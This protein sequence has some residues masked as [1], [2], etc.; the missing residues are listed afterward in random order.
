M[1]HSS[2]EFSGFSDMVLVIHKGGGI[3]LWVWRLVAMELSIVT[4]TQVLRFDITI[5]F[6]E[7]QLIITTDAWVGVD[8]KESHRNLGMGI[9]MFTCRF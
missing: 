5:T 3:G 8:Q 4:F 2:G 6:A 9:N 7:N 1:V